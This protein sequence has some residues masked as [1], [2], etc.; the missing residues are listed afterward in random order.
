MRIRSRSYCLY[1]TIRF[2]NPQI[3]YP[4]ACVISLF[5][6]PLEPPTTSSLNDGTQHLT[7]PIGSVAGGRDTNVDLATFIRLCLPFVCDSKAEIASWYRYLKL[8]YQLW[9]FY[10]SLLADYRSKVFDIN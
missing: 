3:A 4:P 6:L 2:S 7:E 9:Y 5:R 10:I 1:I 8:K